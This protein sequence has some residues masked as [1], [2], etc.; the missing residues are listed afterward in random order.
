MR[1]DVRAA[2]RSLRSS[3]TF[4]T[5]ALLV[6][7]TVVDRASAGAPELGQMLSVIL[8][9]AVLLWTTDFIHGVHPGWVGLGAGLATR[10]TQLLG[11]G[12]PFDLEAA[13]WSHLRAHLGTD[14]PAQEA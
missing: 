13:C 5:V 11:D 1:D 9:V 7:S 12:Y 2:L 6:P 14:V 8:A 3:P 10:L 4:T